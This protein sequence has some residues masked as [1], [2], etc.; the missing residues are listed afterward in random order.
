MSKGCLIWPTW[1]WTAVPNQKSEPV[2][3]LVR[4]TDFWAEISWSGTWYG[5]WSGLEP[6]TVRGTDF[7]TDFFSV[8]YVVRTKISKNWKNKGFIPNFNKNEKYPY[9]PYRR[10]FEHFMIFGPVRNLVRIL[11]LF[12][13]SIRFKIFVFFSI[14]LKSVPKSVPERI[15]VPNSGPSTV[16]IKISY[17]K[18]VPHTVP[19]HSV[20]TVQ[21][22]MH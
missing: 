14:F 15:S 1:P 6:G 11:I 10:N 4:G 9:G 3:N 13:N 12:E 8:R 16:P 21:P 5:F 2:R 22:S 7:G 20:P 17:Q 19:Y 18:S